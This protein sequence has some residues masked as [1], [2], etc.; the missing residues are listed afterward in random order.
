MAGI[1][2]ATA[3]D[4]SPRYTVNFRDPEGKQR[5]KTFRRRA[6]ATAFISTVEA[7][8]LRGAYRHVDAG[9]TT[10]GQYAKE[11]LTSRTFSRS[12][13]QATELRLRLHVLPV[14]GDLQLRHIKPSTVQQLVKG[15]QI[16]PS[17][18]QVVFSHVS[19]I[20]AAAVDDDLI[21]KNPCAA[22]S[23]TRPTAPRRKVVPW[24]HERIAA[25]HDAL[26][27]R[28]QLAVTLGSGAGLRQ[29]EIFGLG[30][31]DIDF[32]NGVI[33]VRRQ[34]KLFASNQQAFGLPKGEKTR[35]VPL[36]SK[37]ADEIAGHL[38]RYPAKTVTLPWDGPGH[39]RAGPASV[40][41]L[42]S[43][44]EA[45]ALNRNFFNSTIWRRAQTTCEVDQDRD[46]GMHALRHWYASILLDAG[47]SIRAVSEYLG[48]ADPGFTLRTYTHLMPT[49]DARTKGAVDSA[50]RLMT[51]QQQ[52]ETT[53]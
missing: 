52:A 28:Y 27:P 31:R 32:L 36:A 30:V 49:S 17:Y 12:T 19:A 29:G 51:G 3:Q 26:P 5:R 38:T 47:E 44:R 1:S 53:P 35:T 43:T 15:W 16:A 6:D 40:E 24:P 20:L 9:R 37:V 41:L 23:V 42:L 46:N 50:F 18:Q 48:H 22:R 14:L 11:W 4:G 21:G 25:M 10:F 33:T 13:H 45:S 7:D 2:K 39:P 34:V 8:K